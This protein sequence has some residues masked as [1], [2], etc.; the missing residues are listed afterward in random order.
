MAD[1]TACDGGGCLTQPIVCKNM[2]ACLSENPSPL[3]GASGSFASRR[4]PGSA[5]TKRCGRSTSRAARR[6]ML[7]CLRILRRPS[8][9]DLPRSDRHS[10]RRHRHT[11]GR[12]GETPSP[13]APADRRRFRPAPTAGRHPVVEQR[14]P[15]DLGMTDSA[16]L[17]GEFRCV[18]IQDRTNERRVAPRRSRDGRTASARSSV[19]RMK[20]C[21]P[22][23][24]EPVHFSFERTPVSLPTRG[25]RRNLSGLA[26]ASRPAGCTTVARAGSLCRCDGR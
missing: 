3:H 23:G 15:D 13:L 7:P 9:S 14:F 19:E 24:R 4:S 12:H 22:R 1:T 6:M 26:R 18:E 10:R 25:A 11:E 8:P 17:L 20:H 16:A 2:H 21:L 5:C